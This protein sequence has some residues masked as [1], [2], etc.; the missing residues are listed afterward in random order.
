[1]VI[2]VFCFIMSLDFLKRILSSTFYYKPK[3]YNAA[4]P[5]ISFNCKIIP[6]KAMLCDHFTVN[7]FC[8][9]FTSSTNVV[10][11]NRSKTV[12]EIRRLLPKLDHDAVQI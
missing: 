9:I 4:L 2:I 7:F 1:M 5:E 6:K 12:V 8:T 3:D 10:K 11:V